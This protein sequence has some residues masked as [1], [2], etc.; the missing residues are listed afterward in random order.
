MDAPQDT[1]ED[2]QTAPEVQENTNGNEKQ[3]DQPPV[4]KKLNKQERKEARRQKNG[5][6]TTSA[7]NALAQEP[8]E[9]VAGKR[10][11]KGRKRNRDCEENGNEEQ[12][13]HN[14]ENVTP[15]KKTK[16]KSGFFMKAHKCRC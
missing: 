5:N 15:R 8:E 9:A 10:G 1:K 11:K 3:N 16:G 2:K 4:K 13:G 14:A 7:D 6:A 12:N